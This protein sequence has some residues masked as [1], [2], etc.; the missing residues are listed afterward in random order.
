M[1]TTSR[2]LSHHLW[3]K[4]PIMQQTILADIMKL[5][6]NELILEVTA[7]SEAVLRVATIY[8]FVLL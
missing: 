1:N 4:F 3:D 2:E 7:A 6:K 5:F 8:C